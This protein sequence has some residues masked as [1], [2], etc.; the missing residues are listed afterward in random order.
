MEQSIPHSNAPVEVDHDAESHESHDGVYIIAFVLLAALTL[1]ELVVT[2]IPVVKAILLLI[3]ASGK[4]YIV[5]AYYMHLRYE[6][7]YMPLVFIG[8]II[9]GVLAI[10]AIQGLVLR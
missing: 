10:L 6:K 5:A 4:A 9:V 8:P 7:R 2:Y 1:V 3:L